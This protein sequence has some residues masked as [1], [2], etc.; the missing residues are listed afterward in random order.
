MAILPNGVTVTLKVTEI[1]NTEEYSIT[2]RFLEDDGI[3]C[4]WYVVNKKGEILN[5]NAMFYSDAKLLC[6]LANYKH[7]H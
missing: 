6:E 1:E 2:D 3:Q 5:N 7:T 4:R